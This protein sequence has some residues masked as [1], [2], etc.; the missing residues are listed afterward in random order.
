MTCSIN[1]CLLSLYD[2]VGPGALASVARL[3]S[4][5]LESPGPCNPGNRSSFLLGSPFGCLFGFALCPPDGAVSYVLAFCPQGCLQHPER[6]LLH[7]GQLCSPRAGGG[8][9]G[10]RRAAA[11]LRWVGKGSVPHGL[12]AAGRREL[13]SSSAR[14]LVSAPVWTG[15]AYRV[16]AAALLS[17][18]F[19]G[20]W[21]PK[22]HLSPGLWLS[23]SPENP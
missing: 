17:C 13:G 18:L 2:Q 12:C 3:V 19:M 7:Q 23:S 4:V 5:S 9:T 1:T 21:F 11:S 16:Q 10:A 15:Q 20:F 14:E 6:W 8:T 22:L